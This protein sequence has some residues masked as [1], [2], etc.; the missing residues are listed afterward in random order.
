MKIR[1]K[2]LLKAAAGILASGAAF[3]LS[4]L[5]LVRL[6]G[7]PGLTPPLMGML[8]VA[9]V[10]GASA[11]GKLAGGW[12]AGVSLLLAVGL[13]GAV[14]YRAWREEAGGPVTWRVDA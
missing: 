7:W 9:W 4:L 12:A 11:G 14:A 2:S 3:S 10:A 8:A 13:V 1:K 6:F 5:L